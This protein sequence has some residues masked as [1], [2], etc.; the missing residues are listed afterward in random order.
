V[1]PWRLIF[2]STLVPPASDSRAGY[3]RGENDYVWDFPREME[4]CTRTVPAIF[5][6]L[7]D[8]SVTLSTPAWGEDARRPIPLFERD[9][10][11]AECAYSPDGRFI[12]YTHVNPESGDG[13]LYIY[14]TKEQTHTPI[15]MAEGYDGGP[16]FSP[17]GDRICYRSDRQG[18]DLLQ[19][20]V[21][22]LAF[23]DE[24]RVIGMAR[25]HQ[26]TDN[27][28]VNWA[29]YWSPDS[30][31]LVYATSEVGHRNYEVFAIWA[32]GEKPDNGVAEPWRVTHA[33]GFD[34]LPVFS[35]DGSL[36]MWTSQRVPDAEGETGSS[37]VWIAEVD[38][39][40]VRRA[41]TRD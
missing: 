35:P 13:N 16:F 8:P 39:D 1:T 23:D 18:N 33:P 5:E 27:R 32:P 7:N 36:L 24:G 3:Q 20:F 31:L 28:H 2:G 22:D 30:D 4:V 26:V 12:V 17:D 38:L 29:P 15:V 6:D 40:A 21:T 14:D 9:G 34:G 11:D 37:Q 10:Y 19:L 25:E 41:G